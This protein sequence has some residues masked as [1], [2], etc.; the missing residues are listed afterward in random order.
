[1]F[2]SVVIFSRSLS[3]NFVDHLC[4]IKRIL[5]GALRYLLEFDGK[6][7]PKGNNYYSGLNIVKTLGYLE[8]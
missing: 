2:S 4:S 5:I 6:L 8:V 3:Y 7:W 1:M